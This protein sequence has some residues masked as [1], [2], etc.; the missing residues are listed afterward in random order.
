MNIENMGFSNEKAPCGPKAPPEAW[1]TGHA[2]PPRPRGEW[3]TE[4]PLIS[5]WS[6]AFPP[7]APSRGGPLAPLALGSDHPAGVIANVAKAHRP[8]NSAGNY[9]RQHE[10]NEHQTRLLR[11]SATESDITI[12]CLL[13]FAL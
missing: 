7:N 2:P 10:T 4:S 9:Q 3:L 5:C 8:K 12:S 6:L 1:K 13:Y 11:G